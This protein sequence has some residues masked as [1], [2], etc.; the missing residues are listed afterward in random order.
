MMAPQFVKPY[1]KTNKNDANDACG[2]AEAITRPDMKFVPNKTI[3]QQDVLLL[4]CQSINHKTK[5]STS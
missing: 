5:N 1:I 3:E 4:P 2:I